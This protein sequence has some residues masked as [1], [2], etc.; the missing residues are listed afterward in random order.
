MALSALE[1]NTLETALADRTVATAIKDMLEKVDDVTAGTASAGDAVI[2]DSNSA[3]AG[4]RHIV[5]SKAA[6]YTIVAADSGKVFLAT[7]A[8]VVFTLPSTAD[9]LEFTVITHTVS[10]G[11]GTSLS[12]A[13]ADAIMGNGL[14]SVDN[15]DLINTGATDAEGDSVTIVG[16]TDGYWI[17]AINGTWAKE[18]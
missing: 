3:V 11:T 14:T 12:P 17:T 1:N 13:A 2:L 6:N 9:G 4:I 10:G 5:E 15:K 7:A 8:D 16:G 18:A